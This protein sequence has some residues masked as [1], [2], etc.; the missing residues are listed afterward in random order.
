MNKK[1]K[2]QPRLIGWFLKLSIDRIDHDSLI[3]DFEEMYHI[4]AQD[5]GYF[6]ASLWLWSQVIKSFF[7]YFIHSFYWKMSMFANYL[8]I[9]IR[10]IQKHKGYSF[11]NITGLS[12]G[13]A[14][15]FLIL[16]WVHDEVRYDR[17][18]EKADELCLVVMED[19]KFGFTW[20]NTSIPIAPAL[21][22]NFSEIVN[23]A[24]LSEFESIIIRDDKRFRERGVFVDSS[25]FSMFTFPL[26]KGDPGHVFSEPFSIVI[27]VEMG[28][29]YFGNEEFIGKILKVGDEADYIVTG[30]VNKAPRNSQ[31]QFDFLLPIETFL[32]KDHDPD[33]WGRFQLNTYVQLQKELPLPVLERKITDFLDRHIPGREIT[34]RLQPLTQIHLY[35][36][37][38]GGTIQYIYIFSLVAAFI[39]IIACINF[40]NLTTARSSN[41]AKEVG[42][43]KV[44]G[45]YK[46][47]IAKQFFYESILLSLFSFILAMIIVSLILPA[48]NNLSSK[49]LTMYSFGNL[50]MILGLIGITLMTGI[51]SGSYPAFFLSSF[52]PVKILKGSLLFSRHDKSVSKKWFRKILVVTQFS[53]SILLII[54]TIVVSNQLN[55]MRNRDLGYNKEEVVWLQMSRDMKQQYLSIKS[56]ILRNPNVLSVTAASQI[57]SMGLKFNHGFDWEGREPDVDLGLNRVLVDH[58]YFET[59]NMEMVQGRSFSKKISA[60]ATD[61]YIVNET[62]VK[63]MGIISPIGKRFSFHTRDGLRKG[64]IIGVVKDF[65][66]YSLREKIEPL[67]IYIEPEECNYICIRIHSAPNDLYATIKFIETKIARFAPD[68]LFE[69]H[70]LNESFDSMYRTEQRL[71][72]IFSYFSSLAILIACLGLFGLAAYTADQRTKEICIRKVLGASLSGVV[73]LLTKEFII[74]VALANIIAWPTAYFVMNNWLQSYAYRIHVGLFTLIVSSVLALGIA[75]IT[76]SLQAFKV[77]MANPINSLRY[78]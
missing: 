46:S 17:F 34:L 6:K 62:A 43:R 28:K 49:Q 21:K 13:M 63:A 74:L 47:E 41:R 53:F 70:F 20:D 75:M 52:K 72:K 58:D 38:G 42:M 54:C 50:Q 22:Q 59:L 31:I 40:M 9:A 68:L 64:T 12:I 32:A 33:N 37:G 69:Y 5:S 1:K 3:G 66:F 73:K 11:I 76:V 48:F 57:P 30:V 45:A 44:V 36:I 67:A 7:A 23:S 8:K 27:T 77:A 25:F 78:E 18:H 51:I 15:C 10:N 35:G 19:H 56:E 55:Y 39:L 24:R 16:L 14:A 71:E 26:I 4:Y 60:D 65:H 29:K 2:K 61:A